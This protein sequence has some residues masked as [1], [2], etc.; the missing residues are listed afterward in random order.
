MDKF[1]ANGQVEPFPCATTLGPVQGHAPSNLAL[2]G[3]DQGYSSEPASKS[4][5]TRGEE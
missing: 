3:S 2:I 4:A 1:L 5:L